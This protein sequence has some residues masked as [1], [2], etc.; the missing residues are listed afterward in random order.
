MSN[1]AIRMFC[2]VFGLARCE[3]YFEPSNPPIPTA[4]K[5]GQRVDVSRVSCPEAVAPRSP[6]AE[7]TQMNK[8]AVAAADFGVAHFFKRRIG[9]RKI[10]PP[11]PMMP[12]KN[13]IPPPKE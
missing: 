6:A 2:T 9:E 11:T 10:P 7:F 1:T 4:S 8:A 3:P 13:P 12:L 5:N